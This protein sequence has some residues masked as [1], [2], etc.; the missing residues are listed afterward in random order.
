MTLAE[1]I[2]ASFAGPN[3]NAVLAV[4][5]IVGI[6]AISILAWYVTPLR[7]YLSAALPLPDAVTLTRYIDGSGHHC[8][9]YHEQN[10]NFC[11]RYGY[12]REA[13]LGLMHGSSAG[14]YTMRLFSCSRVADD[15]VADYHIAFGTA[16]ECRDPAR[17]LRPFRLGNVLPPWNA[18]QAT[19]HS[20]LYRCFYED[21]RSARRDLLGD[22][23]LTTNTSQC[24]RDGYGQPELIGLIAPLVAPSPTPVCGNAVCEPGEVESCPPCRPGQICPLAPCQV[25]TCQQDCPQAVPSEQPNAGLLQ[26]TPTPQKPPSPT[27]SPTASASPA[28]PVCGDGVCAGAESLPMVPGC[29]CIT[30]PCFQCG[31]RCAADCWPATTGQPSPAKPTPRTTPGFEFYRIFGF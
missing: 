7:M 31:V 22:P 9:T 15:R 10:N 24:E 3:R 14:G 30:Y 12:R 13:D 8:Y 6:V 28:T 21:A 1:Q 27:G 26:P 25:G 11:R 5:S 18:S 19:D 23:L 20:P 16:D 17:R 29:S 2:K 4:A